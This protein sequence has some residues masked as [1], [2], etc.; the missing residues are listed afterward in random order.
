MADP[1]EIHPVLAQAVELCG[2]N[3]IDRCRILLRTVQTTSGWP[4]GLAGDIEAVIAISDVPKETWLLLDPDAEG[5][6]NPVPGSFKATQ[7]VDA[8]LKKARANGRR[9]LFV[10]GL[11]EDMEAR[12]VASRQPI[13][14]ARSWTLFSLL[15]GGSLLICAGLDERQ[16]A[17]VAVGG[18]LLLALMVIYAAFARLPRYRLYLRFVK[19]EVFGIRGL[20]GSVTDPRTAGDF[21]IAALPGV[22]VAPFVAI[23]DLLT[24]RGES[25]EPPSS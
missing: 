6:K 15:M 21:F 18:G 17:L 8:A 14:S 4:Q 7:A 24:L 10:E 1:N 23:Y 22:L 20:V 19:G 5:N 12:L 3:Q 13:S 11:L 2:T 25:S 9:S 16:S